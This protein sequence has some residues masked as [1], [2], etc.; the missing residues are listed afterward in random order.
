MPFTI[1][2]R[3]SGIRRPIVQAVLSLDD[4]KRKA[5]KKYPE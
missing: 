2:L 4:E 3:Q 5:N 1:S